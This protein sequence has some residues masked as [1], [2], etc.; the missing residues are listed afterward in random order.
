MTPSTPA[1]A[2]RDMAAVDPRDVVGR[3]DLDARGDRELT[4]RTEG[5]VK[6]FDLETSVIQWAILTCERTFQDMEQG[7]FTVVRGETTILAEPVG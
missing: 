6:V 4:P 1:D 7:G 2:M 3:F 5:G